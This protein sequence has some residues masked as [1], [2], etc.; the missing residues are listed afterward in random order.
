MRRI[1]EWREFQFSD[2][3][4]CKR[5]KETKRERRGGGGGGGGGGGEY[6]VYIE[7]TKGTSESTHVPAHPGLV[8]FG[9][10][11]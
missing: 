5:E 11:N 6:C 10:I 8:N 9:E 7:P 4:H 3:S 1:R 2:L